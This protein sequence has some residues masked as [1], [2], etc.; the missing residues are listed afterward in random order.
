MNHETCV[1]KEAAAFVAN[2]KI[3][4]PAYR[5][6]AYSQEVYSRRVGSNVRGLR[7]VLHEHRQ[8]TIHGSRDSPR[9]YLLRCRSD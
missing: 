8:A 5:G 1:T 3:P 4:G 2:L 7:P 9:G 6:F